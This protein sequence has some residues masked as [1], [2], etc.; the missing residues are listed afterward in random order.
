MSGV[1]RSFI[2]HLL[3]A[4]AAFAIFGSGVAAQG[5]TRDDYIRLWTQACVAGGASK[6][7]PLSS[8]ETDTI[9]TMVFVML[10][11][12]YNAI[13]SFGGRPTK[14]LAQFRA[15]ACQCSAT[16]LAKRKGDLRKPPSSAQLRSAFEKCVQSIRMLGQ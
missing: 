6:A 9:R 15:Q 8:L 2:R 12:Q 1:R 5:P 14:S 7:L 10:E 13:K 4:S 16:E 11:S 3:A